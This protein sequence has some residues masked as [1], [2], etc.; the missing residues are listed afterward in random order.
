MAGSAISSEWAQALPAGSS[1]A[2]PMRLIRITRRE[3]GISAAA[4]DAR[5]VCRK[6]LSAPAILAEEVL[7]SARCGLGAGRAR[8]MLRGRAGRERG[9]A[10]QYR[11]W[12]ALAIRGRAARDLF[13]L[14]D[15]AGTAWQLPWQPRGP[16][17]AGD[18]ETLAGRTACRYALHSRNR[19][20]G[21]APSRP[22]AGVGK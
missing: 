22:W 13:C 8:G 6:P 14:A 5:M 20:N 12:R 21:A 7:G 16:S 1:E 19:G 2:A 9:G 18:G 3:G 4:A 17:F 10:D 11:H 15:R